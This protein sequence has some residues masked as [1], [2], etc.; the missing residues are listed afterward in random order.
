LHLKN[1]HLHSDQAQIKKRGQI[2]DFSAGIDDPE[3]S[4]R[5][6][7]MGIILVIA[8]IILRLSYQVCAR[9]VR[10]G[11]FVNPTFTLIDL[12]LYKN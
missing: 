3:A 8:S 10:I 2:G 11:A 5:I 12:V 7:F 9:S 1:E 6:Q 4:R